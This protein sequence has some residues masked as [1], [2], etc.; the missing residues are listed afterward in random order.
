MIKL[1][2]KEVYRSR[3]QMNRTTDKHIP[4]KILLVKKVVSPVH[5]ARDPLTDKISREMRFSIKK[6]K[7]KR[8]MQM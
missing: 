5:N 3:E 1:L 6:R 2:K 8:K 7:R 4:M